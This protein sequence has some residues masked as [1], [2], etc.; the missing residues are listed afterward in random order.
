M[1]AATLLLLINILLHLVITGTVI[2]AVTRGGSLHA[3]ISIINVY[4]EGS[5]AIQ[6]AGKNLSAKITVVCKQCPS[7]RRGKAKKTYLSLRGTDL[8]NCC[9]NKIKF[10]HHVI[11]QDNPLKK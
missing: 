6:Q 11:Y 9:A 7:I 4:K 3:V 8:L 1:K 5:L 10:R 2:T